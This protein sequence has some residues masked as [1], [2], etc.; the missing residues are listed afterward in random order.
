MQL[1]APEARAWR[2]PVID[3]ASRSLLWRWAIIAAVVLCL[4]CL[5]ARIM[6]YPLQRDE[7]FYIPAGVLFSFKGLYN[8]LN[9]SHFPNLPMVLDALYGITGSLHYVL[10]GRLLIFGA[11]LATIAVLFAFGRFYAQGRLMTALML[12]LLLCN[13]LLLDAAGMAVTNNFIPV[14]FAIGGLLAFMVGI[15]RPIP[16]LWRVALGGF[17]LAI[18]AGFK[19]NYV[20]VLLVIGLATLVLPPWTSFTARLGTVTL[21]LIAGAVIGGLPTLAFFGRDPAGFLV[22]CFSFHRA[23]QIAYWL[24]HPNPVDPKVLGLRDKIMLAHQSWLSSTT[25]VLI[26]AI[27]VLGL[28]GYLQWRREGRPSAIDWRVCLLAAI[29]AICAMASFLPTP[30]FPQYYATPIPFLIVMLCLMYNAI[31]VEGRM[32]AHPLLIAAL[33]LAVICGMP[34]LLPFAGTIVH[35]DRWTGNIVHIDAQSIGPKVR[36][37]ARGGRLATLYPVHALEAGLPIYPHLALGPFIYRASAY[38][39]AGQ[40]PYF[41]HLA[42]PETI[43]G[44]LSREPPAALLVGN[45]DALNKP[46]ADIGATRGY[47]VLDIELNKTE[48]V[49]HPLLM[50][51]TPAS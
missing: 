9:F 41:R 25:M 31:G 7:Q 17:L 51:R 45:M 4:A 33:G 11:W 34:R 38:I 1:M 28:I 32:L 6:A 15:D 8:D 47:R 37:T 12:V 18:A 22:H 43:G 35:P 14:P 26:M 2:G 36:R 13:P 49:D 30:A 44:I 39:P 24:A 21:P 48:D 16:S 3:R 20:P 50:L 5:F 19:A 46:L 27:A 23:P 10:I 42:S 40:R 29:T